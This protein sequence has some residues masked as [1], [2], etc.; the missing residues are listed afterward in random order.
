MS[1]KL[2]ST[3]PPPRP[4]TPLRCDAE[5]QLADAPEPGSATCHAAELL[6]ELQVHQAELEMQNEHLRQSQ[7][8]L[9]ASR[10]RY[11][12][13]YE[14]APVAYLT[15]SSSCLITEINHTG[16][17]M[18]G[19]ER[20]QLLNRRVDA[21]VA[22][23]DRDRWQ[24]QFVSAMAQEGMRTFDLTLMRPD[25]SQCTVQLRCLRQDS[26]DSKPTLQVMMMDITERE[27]SERAVE[28]ECVRLQT[29][30]R[31]ASDGIHIL[32]SDGL[33]VEANEA[34]LTML[35]YD[36]SA[37]GRMRV[38]DW[39]TFDTWPVIQA[40]IADLIA[41]RGHEVFETRHRRR[42][43][44]I[45]DIEINVSGIEIDGKCYLYAASRD[46]TKRKRLEHLL[47]EKNIELERSKVAAENANSAKS[48]FLASMSHELR[49]PLNAILGFAQLMEAARTPSLENQKQSIEQIL[50]A[51]WH[52]LG[53][54]N[55]ILDL[56][57]IESGK[58][59]VSRD[60]IPLPELLTD[61]HAM[62]EPQAQNAGIHLTFPHFDNPCHVLGDL[63]GI[64]QVMINLLSNAIKYNRVD[65]QVRVTYAMNGE[66]RLR[67]SVEDTGV[68]MSPEQLSQL[69]QP[70]NRLGQECGSVE[71]TGIGL[72]VTRQLVELMG[73][74]IGVESN[75]D[76]G[77]VFWFELAVAS[78]P[79]MASG[80]FNGK[81]KRARESD[82]IQELA[83]QRTVLY[84]ED[85][86]SNLALVE[87]LIGLRSDL[88]LLTAID[89]QQGFRIARSG[90]PDLILMDINLHT[91]SG[92]E[93]LKMLR[94]DPLTAHIPV[95]ALS[96]RAIASDIEKGLDAGF[97]QYITKPIKVD[98]FMNA[99]DMA[100]RNSSCR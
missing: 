15:L 78:A 94:E 27:R 55:E 3:V 79:K 7:I 73:G 11:A 24:R 61:C 42:D 31:M 43:G 28:R 97:L 81:V 86:L 30:L 51:G 46:I 13:L 58:M 8:A 10:E 36:Q 64:K 9:E 38:T 45:L 18:L 44:L 76:A 59:T 83:I 90:Q 98:E 20:S 66:Q 34:F 69:F 40:R 74:T 65:G 26:W 50:K 39:D 32:D 62:I 70:F 25:A 77:S 68:G 67:I 60:S 82:Q 75:V 48:E 41:R 1:L 54:I 93:V 6:Y 53:L 96:A 33:L 35:G 71:G 57:K 84:V 22:E 49:T 80:N 100:L 14:F 63:T 72:V 85:K 2:P 5:S 37:V 47:Q 56:A 19:M 4:L 52:L 88:K 92:F 23:S 95:M 99:I 87:G 12:N 89:G 29:I 17:T 91:I 16:A 21:F